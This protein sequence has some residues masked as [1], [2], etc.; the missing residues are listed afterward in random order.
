MK[1]EVH[2]VEMDASETQSANLTFM[3]QM[4]EGCCHGN[5]RAA[6]LHKMALQRQITT[7]SERVG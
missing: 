7:Q 3:L 5:T 6:W 2:K 1:V 4:D